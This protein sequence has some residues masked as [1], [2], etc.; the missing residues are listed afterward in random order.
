MASL[1]KLVDAEISAKR[2]KKKF[3]SLSLSP[4]SSGRRHDKLAP[5]RERSCCTP[6]GS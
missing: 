5:P 3:L 1:L 4:I 6:S 2:E